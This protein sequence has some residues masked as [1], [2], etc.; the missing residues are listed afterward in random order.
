MKL[1]S[2]AH[3]F[4]RKELLVALTIIFLSVCCIAAVFVHAIRRG[5]RTG[6]VGIVA[7]TAKNLHTMLAVWAEGNN[8]EFPTA[9][10]FSNEAFRELFKSKLMDDEKPFSIRGDPWHKNSP[11]GDGTGPDNE[12][13]TTPGYAQALM[14]GECAYAYVSGLALKSDPRLPFVANAF[15]ETLGVYTDDKSHK[16]GIFEGEKC[17]WVTVGGSA[18]VSELSGDFRLLETKD[19][20]KTDV[21][22]KAWGTNPADIK[23]PAG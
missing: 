17:A 15:S 23:N 18:K 9:H 6:R 7:S 16:G 20:K 22:S 13:S 19:G 1:H 8:G 10:Q 3:G 5:S 14:P 12:I 11:S 2:T 4:T 21:F